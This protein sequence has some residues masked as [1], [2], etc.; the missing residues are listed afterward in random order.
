MRLTEAAP[1]TPN[2]ASAS[3]PKY[4]EGR[5]W[6]RVEGA[7]LPNLIEARAGERLR[8]VFRREETAACSEHVLIPSLGKSVMLPPFED[9]PIDL[10]PLDPGDYDF[11]CRLG[12]LRGRIHVRGRA[13]CSSVDVIRGRIVIR[14]GRREHSVGNT[15]IK[16]ALTPDGGGT[17]QSYGLWDEQ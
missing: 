7:F 9:V 15:D 16:P 4:S 8:L 14:G 13:T 10:G 5:A 3:P 11:R 2:E 12:V 6:V 1:T 17:T